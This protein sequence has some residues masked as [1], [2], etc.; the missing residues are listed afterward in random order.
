MIKHHMNLLTTAGLIALVYAAYRYYEDRI[1]PLK[2]RYMQLIKETVV[3][4][5]AAGLVIYF[6]GGELSMPIALA[7]TAASTIPDPDQG[8]G[9][10]ESLD[11]PVKMEIQD[12]TVE[13]DSHVSDAEPVKDKKRRTRDRDRHRRL[14]RHN[15]MQV[16]GFESDF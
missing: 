12:V 7:M 9:P 3:V 6:M 5:L 8:Q 2:L 10:A 13:T 14:D 11:H 4:F 15:N 16:G 1:I